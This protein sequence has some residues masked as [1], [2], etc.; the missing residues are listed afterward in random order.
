MKLHKSTILRLPFPPTMNTYWRHTWLHGRMAV[1]ISRRGRQYRTD[2]IRAARGEGEPLADRPAL[3]RYIYDTMRADCRSGW[4]Y[5]QWFGDSESFAD[6]MRG[7]ICNTGALDNDDQPIVTYC[8]SGRT[9]RHGRLFELAPEIEAELGIVVVDVPVADGNRWAPHRRATNM[10]LYARLQSPRLKLLKEG[11]IDAQGR[12][13]KLKGGAD[14]DTDGKPAASRA[15]RADEPE[16][17]REVREDA[18][19]QAAKARRAEQDRQLRDRIARWKHRFLRQQIATRGM[20]QG[21]W[22]V[23]R[24]LPYLIHGIIGDYRQHWVDKIVS[25][26][27]DGKQRQLERLQFWRASGVF[28]ERENDY[29]ADTEAFLFGL[30]RLLLWPVDPSVK[31]G[32]EVVLFAEPPRIPDVVPDYDDEAIEDLAGLCGVELQAGWLAAADAASEEAVLVREFFELH[33]TDQ[34]RDL[35]AK[36]KREP[37][38]GLS[39]KGELVDWLIGEHRRKALPCPK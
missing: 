6:S 33:T 11:K 23:L 31:P 9:A 36:W 29:Y 13:R 14:E 12:P 21:D 18:E 4:D 5:D 3:L 7:V 35:A 20:K 15:A 24:A 26:L 10:E 28:L 37:D 39:K 16:A 34:L 32:N 19:R 8:N 17:A 30:V 22:Q 38:A 25:H 27:A 2:V 1:L